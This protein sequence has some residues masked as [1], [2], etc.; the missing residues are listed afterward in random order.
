MLLGQ[1]FRCG[2]YDVKPE[3]RLRLIKKVGF[4]SVMFWWGDE[5][6]NTDGS[7]YDLTDCALRLGLKVQTVHFPST[8]AD[9]LWRDE[10][11]RLYVD[12]LIKALYDCAHYGV[13]N[14]VMHTTR[15]LITPPYNEAGLNEFK[16]AVAVAEKEGVNIAVENTR[17]PLYN[18]YIYENIPSKNVTLCY[19]TGHEHC[20]TKDWDILSAFGSKLSTTHIHDNNGEKDEHHLMGEGNINYAPI[21]ARLKEL[22]VT[23]YNLETYCNQSSRY[24]GKLSCEEFL[25]LSYNKLVQLIEDSNRTTK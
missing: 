1:N 16:R 3:E 22:K 5:F 25:Q 17:F 4:D 8:H 13:E 15:Q 24:Y 23:S 19:D 14:L 9:Y 11:R 6:E 18:R 2:F 21:F 20:Y 7:R 10:T 12:M